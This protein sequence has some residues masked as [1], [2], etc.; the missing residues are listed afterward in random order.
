MKKSN[1]SPLFNTYWHA[2]DLPCPSS[3][4]YQWNYGS[5]LITCLTVQILTGVFLA[6]YYSNSATA[7]FDRVDIII[8]DVWLGV[9]FRAIHANG[10]TF[11]FAFMF[12]HIG[13]GI[14]FTSYTQLLVWIAGLLTYLI[15][16]AAAFFGYVLP[17]GQIS[18]WGAI[19]ITG[20]I[21]A[22]PVYGVEALHWFWGAIRLRSLTLTRF[23]AFHFL[24]PFITFG[25]IVVHLIFLHE[26]G[27]SNPLGLKLHLDKIPFHP[28]FTS[29]DLL[30]VLWYFM[31]LLSI[32]FLN[33]WIF[34]DAVNFNLANPLITPPHIQPEWYFLYAYAV[35]R[36][37]P[38]KLGGVVGLVIAIAIL[39]MIP[40]LPQGL[41][42]TLKFY[43]PVKSLFWLLVAVVITLTWL[44]SCPVLPPF[45]NIGKAF[46]LIYFSIPVLI[47][48][49]SLFWDMLL[50][51]KVFIIK[52]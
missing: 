13:R 46:S 35:L 44:G 37:I 31:L 5:L 28:F 52:A 20:L 50:I 25:I 33:P 41:I 26:K 9:W 47:R 38:R 7:A 22:I 15:T 39:F 19:V 40:L 11:F 34:G 29:K 17:W 49:T 8:R 32:S 2:V 10:A 27:R 16:I 43:G 23:F 21:S 51:N 18:Y 3:L 42:Q 14:F 24:F 36:S 1:L 48:I 6:S 12:F 4:S 45:P 30:G